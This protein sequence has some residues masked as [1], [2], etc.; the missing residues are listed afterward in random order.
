[1]TRSEP[2][3]DASHESRRH[4]T[5]RP[6]LAFAAP[7]VLVAA[8]G[9]CASKHA[10]IT[11]PPLPSTTV[12]AAPELAPSS[13]MVINPPGPGVTTATTPPPASIAN[14]PPPPAP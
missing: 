5:R 7:V 3:S 6:R 2:A 9:G 12:T 10:V 14:P 4:S 8:I 1:M 11:N 13:A